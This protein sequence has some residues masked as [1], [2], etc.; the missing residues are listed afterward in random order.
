MITS[1]FCALYLERCGMRALEAVFFALIALMGGTFGYM[2]FTAGVD[3]GAVAKGAEAGIALQ[4]GSALAVVA[5]VQA[6]WCV[7]VLGVPLRQVGTLMAEGRY[8]ALA[9]CERRMR[10]TEELRPA[11][12]VVPRMDSKNIPF[13]VGAMGAMLMPYNLY[14]QSSLVLSRWGSEVGSELVRI[15]LMPCSE[16]SSEHSRQRFGAST[17]ECHES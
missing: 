14:L 7:E 16:A 1:A 8:T 6:A 2:F 3:Y 10:C 13:A 11:G 15:P 9:H 17:L 12:L 4:R 5:T